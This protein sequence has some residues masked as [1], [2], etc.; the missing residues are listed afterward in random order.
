[1]LFLKSVEQLSICKAE[2]GGPVV[3]EIS[4]LVHLLS[5]TPYRGI[6][7]LEGDTQYSTTRMGSIYE[8]EFSVMT[9]RK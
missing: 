1:V 2:S 5:T 7:N 9:R 6:T 8:I 3:K 4:A